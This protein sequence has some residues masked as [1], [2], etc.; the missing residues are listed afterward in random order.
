MKLSV[1]LGVPASSRYFGD[2]SMA[3]ES[4]PTEEVVVAGCS[5]VSGD[6]P[7]QTDQREEL[8]SHLSTRRRRRPRCDATSPGPAATWSTLFPGSGRV[9]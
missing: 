3:Q 5:L 6:G 1:L 8:R 4:E 2:D 9:R 7:T